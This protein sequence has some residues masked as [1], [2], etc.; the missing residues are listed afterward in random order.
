[1]TVAGLVLE[2][3]ERFGAPK[4]LAELDGRPL[5]EH[6]LSAAWRRRWTVVVVLGAHAPEIL[7][8]ADLSDVETVVCDEWHGASAHRFA[9]LSKHFD[10]LD[11]LVVLLADQPRV[12]PEATRRVIARRG[13]GT[14]AIRATHGGQPARPTLFEQSAVQL[15]RGASGDEGGPVSF[16]TA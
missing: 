8:R 10:Y 14:D 1:M 4:Q 6:V 5:L 15:F 13:P 2:P 12:S 7:A 3:V 9:P 16:A 11:A